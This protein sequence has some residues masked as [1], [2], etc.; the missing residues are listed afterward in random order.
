MVGR[1]IPDDCPRMVRFAHPGPAERHQ[2][3]QHFDGNDT[4]VLLR[5]VTVQ[6]EYPWIPAAVCTSS[7]QVLVKHS[8]H[9][10]MHSGW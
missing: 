6:I 4:A 3:P 5:A 7:T 9:G 8:I 2:V 1:L 10:E